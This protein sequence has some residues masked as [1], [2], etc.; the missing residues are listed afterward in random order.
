[1]ALST[2][3]SSVTYTG[4]GATSIFAYSFRIPD[5]A[6]AQIVIYDPGTLTETLLT[7]GVNYTISGID[8][9]AG[10]N[11]TLLGGYANLASPLTVTIQRIMPLTQDMTINN[12]TG[13]L[14]EVL[15][16][17]LDKIVMMIQQLE[18]GLDRAV[19]V[20]VGSTTDPD[21]LIDDLTAAAAAAAASATAAA[22]AATAASTSATAAAASA[23]AA[24]TFNP[25][26]YMTKAANLSDLASVATART[27]LGVAHTVAHVTK[28][29][30]GL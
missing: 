30:G 7:E 1:M 25:A 18:D 23:A 6:D 13:F 12:E 17:Q 3:V 2:V 4:N 24:A 15:M 26:L 20:S 29:A 14:P 9:D 27:N 11:V 5:N 22:T 28:M 16:D 19:K 21:D 8:V 10:G